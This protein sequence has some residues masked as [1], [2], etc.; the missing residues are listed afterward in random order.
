[1]SRQA[2]RAGKN[3][4]LISSLAISPLLVPQPMTACSQATKD[5]K[6]LSFLCS[7]LLKDSLFS[8]TDRRKREQSKN[9][10]GLGWPRTQKGEENSLFMLFAPLRTT[11]FAGLSRSVLGKTV[12]EVLNTTRVRP[13][14]PQAAGRG[15]CSRPRAQVFRIRTDQ[16]RQITCL[17][18]FS[19]QYCFESNFC[20]EF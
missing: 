20:V 12:P 1:M 14:G 18:F 7:S 16:G 15:P 2:K 10:E 3:E 17:L 8:I 9:R 19:L 5:L 6:H 11:L 13:E 4:S